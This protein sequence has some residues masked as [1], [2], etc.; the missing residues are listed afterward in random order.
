MGCPAPKVANNGGGSALMKNPSLAADIVKEVKSAVNVPVTVKMRSGWDDDGINAVELS[1]LCE[2][3]GADAITVHGRT[4]KQMYA[5]PVN[6]D[7]IKAVKQAVDIPVIGNG[8]IRT[9]DDAAKMYEYTGCDFV[10]VGRGAC[11]APWVF[12]QINAYLSECRVLDEP[13]LSERMRVMLNQVQLMIQY[14]G[15][16]IALRE[17]RKH[18]AFYMKG[19]IGAA[20]YRRDCGSITTFEQ[21]CELAYKV[22]R[23]NE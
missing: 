4:R 14:K 17:A 19:L 11:G 2:K 22:C 13:P 16:Y 15:E 10:M 21:L 7:I 20:S 18:A 12:S 6:M 5:P 23:D 8:D 1:R 9:A 3:A